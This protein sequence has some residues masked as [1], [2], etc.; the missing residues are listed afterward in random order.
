MTGITIPI[1]RA[2]GQDIADAPL[3][4]FEWAY[5][6][7]EQSVLAGRSRFLAKDKAWLEAVA[8]VLKQRQ[9]GTAVQL[10]SGHKT[11]AALGC[12]AF[13][14]A[15]RANDILTTARESGHLISPAPA[16]GIIPEGCSIM[17][18]GIVADIERETYKHTGSDER[19]LNKVVLDRIAAAAG[20]DWLHDECVRLDDGSHPHYRACQAVGRIREFDLSWRK[21]ED[22]KEIDLADG[23]NAYQVIIER[24]AEKKR[25]ATAGEPYK[26]DGGAKEIAYQRKHILS[27]CTTEARLRAIRT[28]LGLRTAYTTTE[29]LRPFV[30]VRISFNGRSEN[31]ETQRFFN[32]LIAQ[33]FLGASAALYGA[34]AAPAPQLVQAQPRIIELPEGEKEPEY[35]PPDY[36]FVDLP[37][38]GTGGPF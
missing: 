3:E 16:V 4:D 25:L 13:T 26:G 32:Q 18:T 1:G 6:F 10:V 38:T 7:L 34:P 15:Q 37:K 14:D 28:A 21:F 30:V 35:G 8:P 33:S 2:K 23:G 36:G 12:G 27:L 9:E 24:E 22:K 19:G 17:V 5:N 29:L 11:L 31:P 20:I